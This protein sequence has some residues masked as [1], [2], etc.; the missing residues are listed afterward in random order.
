M[1]DG[2]IAINASIILVSGRGQAEN[3]LE[4][5]GGVA[6]AMLRKAGCDVAGWA[7]VP[8]EQPL[9]EAALLRHIDE[10]RSVLVLTLDVACASVREATLDAVIDT[11]DCLLSGDEQAAC[12]TLGNALILSLPGHAGVFKEDL[13]AML[14]AIDCVLRP[15]CV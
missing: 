8:D 9:I 15:V 13:R 12:A 4:N 6:V 10:L 5:V 2:V 3:G 7:L 1:H 14:C 11:C